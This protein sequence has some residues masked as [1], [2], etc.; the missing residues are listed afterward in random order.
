METISVEKAAANRFHVESDVVIALAGRAA[1]W[2]SR[3][4]DA[5]GF[6]FRVRHERHR[7]ALHEAGHCVV[8]AVRARHV[9][10][11]TIREDRSIKVGASFSG[12]HALIGCQ[13]K[14][15]KPAKPEPKPER[16]ESDEQTVARLSMLLAPR[17]GWRCA[18]QSM[19]TFRNEARAIIERNWPAVVALAEELVQSETMEQAEIEKFLRHCA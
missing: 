6:G 14:P 10:E 12:A 13:E 5:D 11:V 1:E 3:R 17:S 16:V 18:L 7:K 4:R 15:S 9:Y 19:R 2:R 8:G